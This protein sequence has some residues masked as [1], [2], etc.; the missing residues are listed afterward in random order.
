MKNGFLILNEGKTLP[1]FPQRIISLVPSQTELLYELGLGARVSGITKF[2]IH[3]EAWF[4]SK[5]RVGGTKT[6]DLEKV[7][8]L[9]PDLILAN[10]EENEP[11][12][13]AALADIAPVYVSDVH[14]LENALDMILDMGMLCGTEA[15]SERLVQDIRVGFQGLDS[16]NI[17]PRSAAYLIWRKPWMSVGR[18]TF[19]H[20]MMELAGFGNIYSDQDR[21]PELH[22]TDLALREPEFVLLSSEPYPFK[23]KHMAE[24]SEVLPHARIL[25]VDGELFSWYGSRL[26]LAP[27]YFKKLRLES[28]QPENRK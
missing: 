15:N 22:L 13:V 20:H 5:T 18:D 1:V 14:R 24:V 8:A 27:A 7:K 25:L 6:V 2:C 11:G 9:K 10:K 17:R 19:I 12:Q 21:Y 4:R 3:P 28:G 23:E 16:T 26:L